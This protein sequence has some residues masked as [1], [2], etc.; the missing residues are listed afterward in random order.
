MT[1]ITIY[2]L[3]GDDVK[4]LAFDIRAD[5]VFSA[6]SIFCLICFSIEIIFASFV[7]DDYVLGFYFWLDLIATVSLITDIN[8]VMNAM[9]G[10]SDSGSVTNAQQA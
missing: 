1:I 8:D 9:M 5:S 6:L 7:K 2:S 4:A 10:V 3:F